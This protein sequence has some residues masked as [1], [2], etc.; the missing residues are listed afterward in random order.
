MVP[1]VSVSRRPFRNRVLMCLCR[2]LRHSGK[3]P[4]ARAYSCT[5]VRVHGQTERLY[6]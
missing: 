3:P 1:K 5:E 6:A 4:L 2:R